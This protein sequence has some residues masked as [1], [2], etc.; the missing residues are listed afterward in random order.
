MDRGGTTLGDDVLIG[1]CVNVITINH[2]TAPNDRRTTVCK[3][4]VIENNV[5]IGAGVT[6]LPGVTIGKN[7]IIGAAAVMTKDRPP[8]TIAVGTSAKIVRTIE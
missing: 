1:P 6:V 4:I 8:N 2:Q 7:A 5:W 3:P